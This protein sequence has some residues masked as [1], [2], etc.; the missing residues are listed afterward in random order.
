MI[1]RVNFETWF[2]SQHP[3]IPTRGVLATLRLAA[4]GGTIP[5]I[6]RY[7]KEQTGN[8]DEVAIQ[9]I[10][11]GNERW[12]AIVKRQAFI[13]SEIE[14]QKKL[15]TE[16]K[17]KILGTFQMDLLED[18]YLPYKVKRKSKAGLAKE[19]GLEPLANWIWETGHGTEKPLEGQ[20]LEIW[21]FTFRNEEKGFT[22]AAT[23]IAGAQDILIERLSEI[24]ELRQAVRDALFK[25][26]VL[27]SEKA[28]GAKPNSKFEKYFEY[29]ETIP[30][31]LQPQASHR[32]LAIRRGWLEKELK[33]S[34]GGP[35]TDPE[36]E[37]N[38]AKLFDTAACTMPEAP[39]A[40]VLAKAA[41]IAFKAHV[42]PGIEAEVHRQLKEVAETAAI[43]VFSENVRTLLLAPPFGSKP[44]LA[45]DPGIR[46][47]CKLAGIDES[48][49]FSGHW[50]IMLQ[51]DND[52]AKA[53]EILTEAI[54]KTNPMAIA[55]GNG[56]AGREAET[57]VR[58]VL[59]E[60]GLSIP[61]VMV[62]E[63]GA[64]VYSASEAARE[65]FPELDLTIRGAISIGRRLQDPL[66]ELV[67]IDPK[68]IGVG[69]YQH[70]VNPNSLRKSLEYVVDSCVNSVGVNLNTASYHLLSHVSGIGPALAKAIVNHRSEKGLF[71]SRAQLLDIPRFSAKSFEQAAGF[72][73]IPNAANPLDN[74]GVHPERYSSLEGLATRLSRPVS[75]LMGQGV[76]LVKQDKELPETIGNFTFEDIIRELEKPGRDP[77]DSFVPFQFREDIHELKDLTV[78]MLCPGIVTN[79]TNFGAFVDIGVHQDGLV[80]ISQ[81]SDRFIKDPK[82]AVKPGDR[83][84]VR[85]LEVNLEKNQIA[86]SMKSAVER[87]A[88]PPRREHREQPRNDMR[89][90]GPPPP[91]R[92]QRPV[93]RNDAFAALAALKSNSAPQKKK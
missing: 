81:L 39:G 69:Q 30:S 23:A 42:L 40:A 10:V 56:T 5:F 27:R 74:T 43:Q 64:S 49:A 82:D 18:L 37:N 65:E 86:L 19:A 75:D 68:S 58:S 13:V 79:V 70:D 48:G 90:N 85:V 44:V 9:Q 14:T 88:P 31:L 11:E 38:L 41:R 67:K 91:R 35:N 73:R 54:P 17:E 77:R 87:P 32:Y 29:Q 7:R 50:V 33:T 47:G 76:A 59:K 46:T 22:D 51:S 72:L 16:L 83:V 71:T 55:V 26:G 53:K 4:E 80:H 93:F 60:A 36:F 20:T 61:V 12:D 89:R 25:R 28:E 2:Q 34:L 78:G 84:N 92:P 21:A 1:G 63:S 8:L 66:A 15:T 62:S 3:N 6:A 52:K 24:A 45:V 57:F